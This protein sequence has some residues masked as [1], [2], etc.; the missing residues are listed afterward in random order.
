MGDGTQALGP[1][2][3][4]FGVHLLGAL[5]K[6]EQPGFQLV[7]IREEGIAGEGLT[8]CATTLTLCKISCSHIPFTEVN[9]LVSVMMLY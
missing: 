3:I 1:S 9:L 2:S 8:L 7:L 6:V 5:F 4:V